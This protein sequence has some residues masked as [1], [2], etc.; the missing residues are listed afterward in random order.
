VIADVV[1]IGCRRIARCFRGTVAACIVCVSNAC[2]GGQAAS[3]VVCIGIGIAVKMG[4]R[5]L[6]TGKVFKEVPAELICRDIALKY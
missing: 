3:T 4:Y 5:G 1:G 2:I 6:S